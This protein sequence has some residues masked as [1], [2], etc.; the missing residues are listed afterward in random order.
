VGGVEDAVEHR[1][2]QVDVAGRHV[3]PG[4]E[5]PR[6]VR[7]F[8]P[9]HPAEEVEILLDAALAPGAVAPRLFQ[10]PAIGPHV[11]LGLI[12]D[13]G[14]A[15]AD[16]VLGPTVQLL[17]MIGGVMEVFAPIEAEPAHV[18]LDRVDVFLLL[19]GRIG[20]V[21][22]QVAT[23]AE[24]LRHA[25]IE[26]DRLGVA[27]VEIAVR[28][29]REA[30]D[31]RA[32]GTCGEIGADDVADEIAP[33]LHPRCIVCA[34]AHRSVA[35]L[36]IVARRG[37]PQKV[38]SIPSSFRHWAVRVEQSWLSAAQARRLKIDRTCPIRA[39]RRAEP[40]SFRPP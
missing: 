7:E 25:E 16:Q 33:G 4:P 14:L 23:A 17:E 34:H 28:L 32:A 8:A 39:Q 35:C 36:N 6:P 19:L 9:A 1:I 27:D 12:V 30:G 40:R 2:A 10:R 26:A 24:F 20:V 29:R 38:G 15:V 37:M 22:A 11:V 13:I 3:D 5:H 18:A 21:E 31:H